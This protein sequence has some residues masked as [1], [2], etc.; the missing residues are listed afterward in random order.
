MTT[1]EDSAATPAAVLHSRIIEVLGSEIVNG[2]RVAGDRV[3]LEALQ[4]RFGV[5]R[6]V[7]RDCMRV[8]ESLNLVYSKRRVGLVVQD[9]SH[10]NVY[11][12]RVIRW[13]LNGADRDTQFR[14]LTE[15]RHAVEPRAAA[16]AAVNAL[17]EQRGQLKDV[18]ALMRELGEAGALEEFLIADIRFHTLLLHSSGNEMFAALD[19]AIAEVLRGRTHL[20]LMPEH[21]KEEALR[22]HE[23][24]AGAV[25]DGDA[26]AAE[27]RMIELLSEVKDAIGE[28]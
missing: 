4:E 16:G 2:A 12:P 6:T 5:S 26:P 1:P 3:T 25:C 13:R 9:P 20:G 21:P 27:R 24:V 14:S 22:L 17:P 23:Q 18:A 11:D 28:Q 7:M 10:W 19:L 15:L 8:L